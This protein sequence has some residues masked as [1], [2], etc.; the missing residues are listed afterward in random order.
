MYAS[1]VSSL[2]N[3]SVS[4]LASHSL[5]IYSDA[6]LTIFSK[7]SFE[8]S[9]ILKQRLPSKSFLI[10]KYS[11]SLFNLYPN[12]INS[13]RW[14]LFLIKFKTQ[15]ASPQ[16]DFS[17]CCPI[18]A[19]LIPLFSFVIHHHC[20]FHRHLEPSEQSLTCGRHQS[21]EFPFKIPDLYF[22]LKQIFCVLPLDTL[23][24][25]LKLDCWSIIFFRALSDP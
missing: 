25:S 10:W 2:R 17:V 12:Y 23:F 4:Q 19:T 20:L 15:V 21:R 5:L 16:L 6:V 14:L 9:L 18:V 3:L 22:F 13:F 11:F 8:H 1:A 7:F 24:V